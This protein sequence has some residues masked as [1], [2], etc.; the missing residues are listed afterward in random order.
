MSDP[1]FNAKDKMLTVDEAIDFLLKHA[2]TLGQTETVA[3]ESALGRVLAQPI[4]S[5]LNVPPLD[6]SAMDGYVVNTSDLNSSADTTLP[7]SQRI[8]AGAVGEPLASGTAARIFTGAPIP[9]NADAV[10]MQEQCQQDGDNVIITGTVN[11]ADHIRRAGEDI[12][13]GNT[14]MQAGQCLRPQDMGLIAS[15][16][17]AKINVYKK[18]S[19]AI[20]STGDELVMPGN[21]VK[22]GQIYNSNRYTLTGL[23]QSVGCDI[24]DLGCVP[25]TLEATLEALEKAS[26][27][28]DLIMT[29]GG[30]SVGEEDY[31]K[32]AMEKLGSVDMWRVAMKPGKPIAYG[33]VNNVPFIGLPGNPVSVFVTFC[34]FA[35]PFIKTLQGITTVMPQCM[36]ITSGFDWPRKGPRREFVR[37]QLQQDDAGNVV[38]Q[39]FSSQSSG[40]LTS[41]VWAHGLVEI[42]EH[43][44][45]TKGETVNWYGFPELLS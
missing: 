20:F 10:I 21:P 13:K 14:V 35:R 6:N 45:V 23:L 32:A 9:E 1:C 37:A 28:A 33:S 18:V 44:T 24:I 29:T 30:V 16:G 25:D 17:V 3:I 36:Q 12:T 22:A 11:I 8:P 39:C 41:A 42:S 40:V 7:I 43:T 19:V 2:N 15:V 38:A 26:N 4:E 34:L 31:V 5:T 27:Q